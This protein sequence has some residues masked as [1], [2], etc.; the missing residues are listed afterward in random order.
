MQSYDYTNFIICIGPTCNL[1]KRDKVILARPSSLN[2]MQNTNYIVLPKLRTPV[3]FQSLLCAGAMPSWEGSAPQAG[4]L[5]LPCL[6]PHSP[7]SWKFPPLPK[8]HGGSVVTTQSTWPAL[9]FK[10]LLANYRT[11]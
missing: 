8:S 10:H 2:L 1:I 11:C 5:V 6:A 7:S 4:P 3:P 9:L